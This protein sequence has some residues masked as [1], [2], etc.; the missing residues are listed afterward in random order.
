MPSLQTRITTFLSS[1]QNQTGL[2][3]LASTLLGA[4]T[5]IEAHSTTLAVAA[6]GVFAGLLHLIV[7]DNTALISDAPKLL[8]DALAALASKNPAAIALI[9]ADAAK[10]AADTTPTVK[11]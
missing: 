4:I 7:P 10:V 8:T 1:P 3:L 5:Q 11:G 2:I 9:L 6:G